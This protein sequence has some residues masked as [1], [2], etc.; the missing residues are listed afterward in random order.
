MWLS[1]NGKAKDGNREK[2]LNAKAPGYKGRG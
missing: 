2:H 1:G